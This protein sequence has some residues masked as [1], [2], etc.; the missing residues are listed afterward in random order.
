[1]D[2]DEYEERND[3]SDTEE[4]I[5]LDSEWCEECKCINPD[6]NGTHFVQDATNKWRN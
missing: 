6:S 4:Q 1:M 5:E 2:R 3:W